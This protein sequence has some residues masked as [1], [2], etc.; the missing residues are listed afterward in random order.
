LRLKD[1]LDNLT[2]DAKVP[3]NKDEVIPALRKEFVSLKI[4]NNRAK[5]KDAPIDTHYQ[6]NRSRYEAWEKFEKRPDFG[7]FQRS[8]S[9]KGFYRNQSGTYHKVS[10][11]PP[12]RSFD[13][14]Q[15][16]RRFDSRGR[17]FDSNKS[18][19]RNN[20]FDRNKSADR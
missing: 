20:S 14:S 19:D 7:D 11:P 5:P 15:S 6:D 10:H 13:R 3:K 12:G 17:S 9:Q 4:E 1:S 18:F 16:N 2:G 8:K